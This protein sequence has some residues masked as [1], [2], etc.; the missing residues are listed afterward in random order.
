MTRLFPQ[1]TS[2]GVFIFIDGGLLALYFNFVSCHSFTYP[3]CLSVFRWSISC[4]CHLQR[5]KLDFSLP[6]TLICLSCLFAL[7][8]TFN[9]VPNEM[10]NLDNLTFYSNDGNWRFSAYIFYYVRYVL[11]HLNNIIVKSVIWSEAFPTQ[12]KSYNFFSWIHL[13]YIQHFLVYI[14][15]YISIASHLQRSRLSS[16]LIDVF[17]NFVYKYFVNI[18]LWILVCHFLCSWDL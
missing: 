16:E 18:S 13:C 4:S 10:E 12:R 11:S 2:Q 8:K 1:F 14:Y 17:L 5:L 6:L 7:G 3:S 9:T 15:I